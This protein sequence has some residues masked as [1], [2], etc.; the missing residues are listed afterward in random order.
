LSSVGALAALPALNR[1]RLGVVEV[2][3]LISSVIALDASSGKAWRNVWY[4]RHK[5]DMPE[6]EFVGLGNW[7]M[8]HHIGVLEVVNMTHWWSYGRFTD[9]AFCR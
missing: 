1:Q 4:M 3:Y 5:R 7:A 9:W 2:H 8:F 6:A